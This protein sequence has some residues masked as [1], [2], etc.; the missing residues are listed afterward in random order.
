MFEEPL[1]LD[2][3]HLTLVFGNQTSNALSRWLRSVLLHK[4]GFFGLDD[5]ALSYVIRRDGVE[6]LLRALDDTV[7]PSK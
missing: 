2:A 1:Q 6:A 4:I 7:I 3:K 5:D